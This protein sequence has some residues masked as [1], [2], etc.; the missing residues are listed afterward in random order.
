MIG[1]KEMRRLCRLRGARLLLTGNDSLWLLIVGDYGWYM[2][3][4]RYDESGGGWDGARTQILE[5]PG[6]GHG[7]SDTNFS[8][9]H[10]SFVGPGNMGVMKREPL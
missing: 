2:P 8:E 7:S 9:L 5:L 3:R 4:C 6:R 10:S 1:P